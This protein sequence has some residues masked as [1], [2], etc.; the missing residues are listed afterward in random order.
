MQKEEERTSL[1]SDSAKA[2]GRMNRR[3]ARRD[4]SGKSLV[5]H[6]RRK[7]HM[8]WAA[9]S[10]SLAPFRFVSSLFCS[11]VLLHRGACGRKLINSVAKKLGPVPIEYTTEAP[12]LHEYNKALGQFLDAADDLMHN[13]LYD[14]DGLEHHEEHAHVR[15]VVVCIVYSVC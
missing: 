12:V 13:D 5:I 3:H 6:C 4:P 10:A 9:L 15:T 14:D 2:L 8:F 7:M 1:V 11:T